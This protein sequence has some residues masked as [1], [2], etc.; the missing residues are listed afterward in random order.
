MMTNYYAND[1]EHLMKKIIDTC[2]TDDITEAP[3]TKK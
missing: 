3:A 1:D 2:L